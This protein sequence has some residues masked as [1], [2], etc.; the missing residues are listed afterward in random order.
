MPNEYTGFT[1]LPTDVRGW[2]GNDTYFHRIIDK[3]RPKRIIEVGTW[4]GQSAI[5][6][7]KYTQSS[8]LKCDIVCVDTWLGALEFIEDSH[9]MRNLRKLHGY[10]QVYYQFLSNIINEGVADIIR[11]FPQTSVI[12]ARHFKRTNLTADVIYIDGSHDYDDVKA[13]I[14]AYWGLVN[15]GGCLFGD[16]Y[17]GWP[18]VRK[19]VDEFVD[20]NN[21]NL[22]VEGRFWKIGK[23]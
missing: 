23:N 9:P 8:G 16:D 11:P 3:Y 1:P 4:L 10:P 5:N 6:M 7:A 14:N 21:L 19:A 12:A 15:E 20:S 17:D 22:E 18:E 2:G 13:D